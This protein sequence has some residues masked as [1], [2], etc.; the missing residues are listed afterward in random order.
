MPTTSYW[1]KAFLHD[2]ILA[3]STSL[4][5]VK[6]GELGKETLAAEHWRQ[7]QAWLSVAEQVSRQT[8]VQ[9]ALTRLPAFPLTGAQLRAL[10]SA[11]DGA[12]QVRAA[13]QPAQVG[14]VE[15]I[16]RSALAHPPVPWQARLHLSLNRVQLS[17]LAVALLLV[18]IVAFNVF[19]FFVL[20]GTSYQVIV[21]INVTLAAM[22]F[23][24]WMLHHSHILQHLHGFHSDHSHVAVHHL[25]PL[26]WH[27][28]HLPTHRQSGD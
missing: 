27:H 22:A 1:N 11:V 28:Y 2:L 23:A 24:V 3:L 9:G 6:V 25:G 15:R 12:V 7:V 18:L 16:S 8:D 5:R 4:D 26:H 21:A 17:S 20:H 10:Q 13:S 19:D 14:A